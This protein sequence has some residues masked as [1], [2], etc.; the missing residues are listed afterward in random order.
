MPSYFA[1]GLGIQS[2]LVLP[3]FLPHD[4]PCDVTIELTDRDI[5]APDL[6]GREEY[7][8]INKTSALLYLNEIGKFLIEGGTK[9]TVVLNP[10]ADLGVVQ[11]IIIGTMMAILLFQRGRLVLHGSAIRIGDRAVA[12]LGTSGA[13]KS[14]IA[15]ALTRRGHT[16]ITD[17]VAP[18]DLSGERPFIVPGYPMVKVDMNSARQL[19]IETSNLAVL[20]TK[21]QKFG[22]QAADDYQESPCLLSHIFALDYDDVPS[23]KPLAPQDAFLTILNNTP[24]TMWG[25]DGDSA[26]FQLCGQLLR[27]TPLSLFVRDYNLSALDAHA[28]MIEDFIEVRD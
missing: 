22:C 28:R 26:H 11:V 27:Q 20:P 17:D 2:D 15:A 3:Q 10:D 18:I 8:D 19:G 7:H 16:L 12:F 25:I 13:G 6:E 4:G 5:P 14:T 23:F 1:Y 9:I 21:K 24:P